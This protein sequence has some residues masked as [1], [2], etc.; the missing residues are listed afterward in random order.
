MDNQ[1]GIETAKRKLSILKAI[2]R[3]VV[4][5][6]TPELQLEYV[7]EY[8][9]ASF[10][11]SPDRAQADLRSAMEASGLDQETFNE[12]FK[13]DIAIITE[14]INSRDN[15]YEVHENG[16][17]IVGTGEKIDIDGRE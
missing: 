8:G 7:K 6:I 11:I 13:E 17:G 5:E 9:E 14:K 2:C 15:K 10:P 1:K 3:G 12:M 16:T 4:A